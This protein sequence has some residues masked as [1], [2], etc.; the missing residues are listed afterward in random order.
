MKYCLIIFSSPW[1]M[2][3]L[4]LLGVSVYID[5]LFSFTSLVI[6][7]S[8]LSCYIYPP[9]YRFPAI[10]CVSLFPSPYITYV[11]CLS[12]GAFLHNKTSC[13]QTPS[14]IYTNVLSLVPFHLALFS[15]LRA[16]FSPRYVFYIHFAFPVAFSVCLHERVAA[17]FI[18]PPSPT[19]N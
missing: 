7:V 6:L 13:L 16:F 10:S 19:G 4:P 3:I 2:H 17:I 12:F 5:L 14:L 1:A 8:Y 15:P 18:P 9:S 11:T